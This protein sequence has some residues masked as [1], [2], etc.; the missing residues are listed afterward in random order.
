MGYS[1]FMG[2]MRGIAMM[3]PLS[4]TPEQAKDI[5]TYSL[6]RKLASVADRLG[7]PIER[8]A[9]LGDWRDPI[10]GADGRKSQVKEPMCVRYSDARLETSACTRRTCLMAIAKVAGKQGAADEDLRGDHKDL[11]SDVLGLDWGSSKPGSSGTDLASLGLEK[12]QSPFS[13]RSR[14]RLKVEQTPRPL[15]PVP[16]QPARVKGVLMGWRRSR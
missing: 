13:A 7:M 3:P 6:R 5:T 2:V 16:I 1:K 9:E 15:T 14:A 10:L 12:G 4:V 8:R 11:L